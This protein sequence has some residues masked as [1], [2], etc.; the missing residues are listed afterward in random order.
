MSNVFK[1]GKDSYFSYIFHC[2]THDKTVINDQCH[3]Y[4]EGHWYSKV[5]L[6]TLLNVF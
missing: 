5:V 6:S 3:H 4:S 1:T 2:L